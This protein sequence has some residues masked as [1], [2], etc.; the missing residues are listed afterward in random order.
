MSPSIIKHFICATPR[1]LPVLKCIVMCSPPLVLSFATWN[2]TL[3]C[4]FLAKQFAKIT[5]SMYSAVHMLR[6]K[7][8]QCTVSLGLFLHSLFTGQTTTLWVHFVAYIHFQE[9]AWP[10]RLAVVS[11]VRLKFQFKPL[12]LSFPQVIFV[13]AAALQCN[14]PKVVL[15]KRSLDHTLNTTLKEV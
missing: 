8:A 11:H 2:V 1:L 10:T 4:S 3:K 12:T 5:M 13:C 14:G 15:M 9:A 6:S 7:R